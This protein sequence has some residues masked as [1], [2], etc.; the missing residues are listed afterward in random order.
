MGAWTL[1]LTVV[2]QIGR[3]FTVRGL[4]GIPW[5]IWIRDV[6]YWDYLLWAGLFVGL[7]LLLGPWI[8]EM[9]WFPVLAPFGVRLVLSP[10]PPTRYE[11]AVT[12]DATAVRRSD[13]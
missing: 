6:L 2:D 8:V 7:V 11:D 1:A 9:D 12:A 3:A 13:S 4:A 5:G 10:N